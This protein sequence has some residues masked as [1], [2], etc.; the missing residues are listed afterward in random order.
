MPIH[1]RVPATPDEYINGHAVIGQ[2]FAMPR[3]DPERLERNL[4]RLPM[5]RTQLAF[6]GSEVVGAAG[7]YPFRLSVPGG[8]VAC[9]GV[10]LVGVAP[11]HRRQGVLRAMMRAQLDAA[12]NDGEPIAAL[13]ASEESIYGRFGY[14]VASWMGEVSLARE[15]SGFT[16]PFERR[17][18]FRLVDEAE[19]IA[20]CA[21]VWERVSTQ[22]AGMFTR[23][24]A[25]WRDRA[26]G[27]PAERREPGAGPKRIVLLEQEG[28]VRGY[29]VYRHKPKIVDHVFSADLDIVEALAVDR[30]STR[31]LWRYLLEMDLARTFY[32]HRLPLDHP[33]L[34]MV[35]HPRRLR[36]QVNDAVWIRIVDVGAALSGRHYATAGRL[37]FQV[38]DAFCPWNE[39]RW[40]LEDGHAQRT[41]AAADLSLNV[42][43]LG[44]AYLGGVAFRAMAEAF[45]VDELR[46]GAL[47]QADA[48]F[49]TPLQPWCPEVF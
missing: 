48:M 6:D 32:A 7:A 16:A 38:R 11:T 39:G 27:D 29:A 15:G 28:E 31:E 37:V 33:L 18:R 44:S 5:E 13:W 35:I 22:R 41:E 26:L 30:E 49:R 19:A 36:F 46:P 1:V 24:E 21:R 20:P 9:A 17:G 3:L 43:A 40:V 2:Y 8:S 10:T 4:R 42:D 12:R 47:D 45:R 25:W 14:G 34:Q 23:S